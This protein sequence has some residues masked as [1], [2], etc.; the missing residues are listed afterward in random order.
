MMNLEKIGTYCLDSAPELRTIHNT[1]IKR[2]NNLFENVT[3]FTLLKT[4]VFKQKCIHEEIKRPIRC[5]RG[6]RRGSK[7]S[8]AHRTFGL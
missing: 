2:P 6:L 7:L 5:S 8:S 3:S 1:S 4:T